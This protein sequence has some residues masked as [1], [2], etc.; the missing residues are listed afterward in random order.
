MY[1]LSNILVH[2]T[3][4]SVFNIHNL[5]TQRQAIVS[6]T[7]VEEKC[8]TDTYASFFFCKSQNDTGHVHSHS[9]LFVLREATL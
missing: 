7:K 8:I 6:L 2:G 3:R 4:V 1:Q 9:Q 5:I